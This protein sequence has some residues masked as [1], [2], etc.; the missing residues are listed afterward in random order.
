[1]TTRA[2]LKPIALAAALVALLAGCVTTQPS[3]PGDPQWQAPVPATLGA[4]AV[5]GSAA[6]A[7]SADAT[8]TG[9][10]SSWTPACARPSP[11]R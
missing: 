4:S 3:G 9:R 6:L 10:R 7:A 1:M 5:A 8:R 11:W 2:I